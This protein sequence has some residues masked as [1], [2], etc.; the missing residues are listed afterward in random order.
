MHPILDEIDSKPNTQKTFSKLSF[1][2]ALVTILLTVYLFNLMPDKIVVGRGVPVI[3]FK[4]IFIIQV[5]C[6]L[7]FVFA[8]ISLVKKEPS[9]VF[10]WIGGIFNILLFLAAIGCV[11]FAK[12]VNH[13]H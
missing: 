1:V 12:I 10:K 3:P 5:T 6:L 9:S 4:L 7:G 11:I 13:S 8:I 2:A